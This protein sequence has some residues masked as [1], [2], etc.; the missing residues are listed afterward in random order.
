[1]AGDPENSFVGSQVPKRTAAKFCVRW[2]NPEVIVGVLGSGHVKIGELDLG[3]VT[4]GPRSYLITDSIAAIRCPI[5]SLLA[6]VTHLTF[7]LPAFTTR[8]DAMS[9]HLRAEVIWDIPKLAPNLRRLTMQWPATEHRDGPPSILARDQAWK[10][11]RFTSLECLEILNPKSLSP[12]LLDAEDF[13]A[14]VLAHATN[15]RK[16]RI[17]NTVAVHPALLNLADVPAADVEA[18]MRW[19]MGRLQGRLRDCQ[20]AVTIRREE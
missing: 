20:V 18:G 11:L 8:L 12:G 4:G 3:D 10:D 2:S 15:L 7:R 16:V 19:M 17:S 9:S 14:F 13:T 1:M 5:S 6:N